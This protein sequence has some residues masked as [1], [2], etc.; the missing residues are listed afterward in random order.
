MKTCKQVIEINSKN[1][2]RK[3]QQVGM[4]LQLKLLFLPKSPNVTVT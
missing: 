2:G 3:P 1:G 4:G